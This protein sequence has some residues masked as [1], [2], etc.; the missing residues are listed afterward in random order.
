MFRS[1]RRA[2]ASS[3]FPPPAPPPPGPS[4]RLLPLLQ[5]PPLHQLHPGNSDAA[6]FGKTRQF[7]PHPPPPR[8]AR[9]ENAASDKPRLAPALLF[10][11][12]LGSS[13]RDPSSPSGCCFPR[14]RIRPLAFHFRGNRAPEPACGEPRGLRAA[15]GGSH[16]RGENRGARGTPSRTKCGAAGAAR[17]PRG[18]TAAGAGCPPRG[19]RV[20][21]PSGSVRGSTSP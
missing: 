1:P 8:P 15:R 21:R 12:G 18:A 10:L 5:P 13:P 16:L 20:P 3:T 19:G 17:A 6:A 7:P 14:S 2:N 11:R 9:F 4:R